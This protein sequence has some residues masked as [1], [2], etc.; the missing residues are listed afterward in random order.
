MI[1]ARLGS[2]RVPNKSLRLVNGK[3]LIEYAIDLALESSA[4]SPTDIFTN[5]DI[6]WLRSLAEAKGVSFYERETHLA[7]DHSSNDD[8]MHD[9][10]Q[11]TTYDTYFQL[12]CTSPLLRST[13]LKDFYD[14]FH[15][16][17]ISTLI[18][19]KDINIECVF[20]NKPVNFD[21]TKPTPRSQDITPIKAYACSLMAWDRSTYLH[22][23]TSTGAAYHGGLAPKSYFTIPDDET[24]DVDNEHDFEVARLLMLNRHLNSSLPPISSEPYYSSEYP[25]YTHEHYVPSIL[26]R[27][28]VDQLYL[29]HSDQ[30]VSGLAK[31]FSI[32]DLVQSKP[33]DTSW[34][35]KL[36]DTHSNSACL[37]H[38]LPGEGNRTHMH[39]EWD[40][41]WYIVRGPWKYIIN[42]NDE[43]ILNTGDLLSIPRYLHHRIVACGNEPSIRL[44]VSRQDVVHSYPQP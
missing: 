40:E 18:S 1:P 22:N 37:I 32:S 19:V 2:K 17:E 11:K 20:D 41:W 28:L 42:D 27:D 5:T 7:Q 39:P 43:Y 30:A 44:A 21:S 14:T 25:Q 8:F 12:L 13:T 15:S 10:M 24:I 3:P 6:P 34:M 16:S 35:L 29:E 4:F 23:I 9:F 36:V 31:Q 26:T 38:Q 33:S